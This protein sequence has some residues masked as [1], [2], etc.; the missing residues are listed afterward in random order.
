LKKIISISLFLIIAASL[1]AQKQAAHW[2]F[3]ENAGLDFNSGSPIALTDGQMQTTEGCAT[4]SDYD[5]NLLFYTNGVTIWNKNHQI[6]VN[7]ENLN[8]DFSSTNS[9][10][11][12]PK[13]GDINI[14]YVF[15]VDDR[16]GTNG[17]QYS[18]VNMLSSGGLGGVTANKN[19]PLHN[20]TTEKIT[21]VKHQNDT[22]WWV[23]SHKWDNNEFYAYRISNSGIAS[24]IVTSIGTSVS[25]IKNNSIGAM[26]FSPDASKV[27]LA[28]SY[29]L[30]HA[31][32]LDFDN[33]TGQ[34]SNPI[35]FAGFSGVTG[36]YGVEFSLDS[37][38]LY[39]SDSGGS[40]YQYN[41]EL[42]NSNDII[43]SR[44]EITSSIT[45]LGALQ[46]A[47]N[48][49][50]YAAKEN[51]S[52]LGVINNPN[53]LGIGSNYIDNGIFL[54]GPKS[55][56]GLPPFIQSFFWKEVLTEYTCL[57]DTTQFTLS[58]PEVSQVWNFN[59]PITGAD[60]IS[61][62][63]APS[64]AFSDIGIYPVE[65][66]TINFLGVETTTIVSVEIFE[67]P[68]ATMPNNYVLC[69]DDN[70]G[71]QS[72][73][74]SNIDTEILGT[75]DQ[76]KFDV[77]YYEDSLLSI[78][79]DKNLDYENIIPSNQTIYAKVFN[80][81]NGVCFEKVEFDL[82]VIETPS[83]EVVDE[84]VICN[85]ILPAE[86]NID[87]P[88]DVYNYEWRLD[89]GTLYSNF[90]TITFSNVDF[91]PAEGLALNITA[92][93][94]ITT[95]ET[96]KTVLVRKFDFFPFTLDDIS[97]TDL[98]ENN[99]IQINTN[100]LSY[101]L[102]EYVYGID[103]P[104]NDI[105]Q[106]QNEP[107]FLNVIPGIRKLYIKDVLNCQ[108]FE[109]EIPIISFQKFFTPN[110]DGY[111]DNWQVLGVNENFHSTSIINI[112]DR[113][114]KLIANIDPRSNG[115]DGYY[116]GIQLP[117][118]DYWFRVQLTNSEGTTLDK[119]GHFSLIRR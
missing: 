47:P 11:I 35:T 28:H 61:I 75:I 66:K 33:L 57:G 54:N 74:L 102:E 52:S 15:T 64:H 18:E 58:N 27:A 98:S 45:G 88:L 87:N 63:I 49:K 30:N 4:I 50:I 5:G 108:E 62:D 112:Y 65:V 97:I 23:L 100:E 51:S 71:I 84:F 82:I 46:I 59:D 25:G 105:I 91:I 42:V 56:F 2:Y 117:A 69:D 60:N 77:A 24:P 19:V 110:N 17:L 26:K 38:L 106:F 41:T 83:F 81:Q 99:T 68:I 93:N 10:I 6:M 89:D 12:I 43:N 13:P 86:L 79:I 101:N 36:V 14:Y 96:T 80:L 90:E 113:F 85:N 109:F 32:L 76:S 22:D 119:K 7:G 104:Y 21:A 1:F 53:I 9:A 92:T 118:S 40:I 48:G 37:K 95:C 3:G 107:I 55:K 8:G 72:F 20:P 31:Q 116:N 111:N 103:N 29:N 70:D 114:G 94:T 78:Q 44:I 16:G 34:L 67:T 73:L 115:W 39:L